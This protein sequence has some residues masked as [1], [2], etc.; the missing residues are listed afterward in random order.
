MHRTACS[1]GLIIVAMSFA[2]SGCNGVE[3]L[4]DPRP[5]MTDGAAVDPDAAAVDPDA[6]P[7]P[8]EGVGCRFP[9]FDPP[10]E[11]VHLEQ[12]HPEEPEIPFEFRGADPSVHYDGSRFH[13]YYTTGRGEET[14]IS[15]A[16]SED[17]L[18]WTTDRQPYLPV[19]AQT[20]ADWGNETASFL[21][22]PDG[23]RIYYTGY[24]RA[25]GE[26]EKVASIGVMRRDETGAWIPYAGNP[27]VTPAPN[28]WRSPYRAPNGRISGGPNEVTVVR[29]PDGEYIL[30]TAAG[31][32]A[33]GEPWMFRIGAFRSDD[34]FDF[35]PREDNPVFVPAP[36]PAWDRQLVSHPALL[37]E[38]DGSG[39]HLF[40]VGG[41]STGDLKIGHAFSEDCTTGWQ[42]N[43]ANP[44]VDGG[45][46]EERGQRAEENREWIEEGGPAPV[47]VD[48]ELRLYFMR[49]YTGRFTHGRMTM[50]R[51]RCEG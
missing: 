49:T 38:P 35:Q 40:Y 25:Q 34:G 23:D 47:M 48:G 4:D 11:W 18:V 15:Y 10:E 50:V 30:L 41:P 31:A 44:I 26:V 17:G 16:T 5:L 32:Q 42:R 28:S 45:S 22:D 19:G 1:Y 37:Q 43:P 39:C 33:P 7:P 24:R 9:V 6:A 36:S 27:I 12:I 21:S 3:G 2:I 20:W 13:M 51:G 29:R 8:Q 14:Y 46:T